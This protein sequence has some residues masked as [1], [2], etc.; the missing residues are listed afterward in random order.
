MEL[1][2]PQCQHVLDQD[3]DHARCPSCMRVAHPAGKL[4]K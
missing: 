3:N 1:H 2:C 4:L